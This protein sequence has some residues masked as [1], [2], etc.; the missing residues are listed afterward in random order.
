MEKPNL[1][2]LTLSFLIFT[3][4]VAMSAL[5]QSTL[6]VYISLFVISYFATSAIFSPRKITFDLLGLSLFI[7][8]AIIVALRVMSILGI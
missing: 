6:D 2:L 7:V 3:S 5:G 8:F 4:V 1:Y